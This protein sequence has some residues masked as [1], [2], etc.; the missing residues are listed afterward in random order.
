MGLFD[1]VGDASGGLMGIYANP[2]RAG[3]LGMSQGLLSA[4]GPSRIPVS[5]GQALGQG[6]Q[7]MQQNAG[8][9]LQMQQQ[10]MRMQAMQ[11]LMGGNADLGA[12]DDAVR[13]RVALE[14]VGQHR[15]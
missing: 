9:A 1:G 5:M 10:M 13:L 8:N 14:A 11:W 4:S 12:G 15:D 6:M 2:Q 3:L 7:G